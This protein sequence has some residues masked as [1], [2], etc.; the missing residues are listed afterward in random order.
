MSLQTGLTRASKQRPSGR[1]FLARDDGAAAVEFA[2]VALPFL[3]LTIGILEV[4]VDYF[5]NSQIDYATQTAVEDI[6]SGRVQAQALTA[7]SF[8]TNLLCARL[9]GLNCDSLIVNVVT[10]K[11]WSDWNS[12][13]GPVD[14]A[15]QKWCPGASTDRVLVQ[16]AY[17]VPLATMIWSGSPSTT[18][19]RYFRA[20]SGF[21]NDPYGVTYVNGA[22]C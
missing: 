11:A 16:V 12:Y 15:V 20:S 7:S 3:A 17:P 10:I 22:G 6:R 2:M 19:T 13:A 9:A 21:R 1:R 14:P 18:T 4:G 8:K 5:I